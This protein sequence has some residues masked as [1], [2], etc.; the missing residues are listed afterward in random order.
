[1][2]P[3]VKLI[4]G[5]IIF[6]AGIYW[7]VADVVGYNVAASWLGASALTALK[8]VFIGIFGLFLIFVGL[9]VA[10]IEWEDWKWSREEKQKSKK[11]K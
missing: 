3:G 2:H 8:T 1:M 10:W 7:Y 5:I 4:I 6:L 9:I 11:K